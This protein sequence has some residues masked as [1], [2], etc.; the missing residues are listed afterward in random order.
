MLNVAFKKKQYHRRV[1]IEK[2]L[3]TKAYKQTRLIWA[4][5]YRNWPP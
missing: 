4:L 1:V 3:L 5:V 2:P